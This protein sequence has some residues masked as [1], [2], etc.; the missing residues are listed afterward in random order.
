MAPDVDLSRLAEGYQHRPP[1]DASLARARSA[2]S[3]LQPGSMILDV[4]GG[5]GHHAAVWSA[6]GHTP[7]VLDPGTEMTKPA[8]DRNVT[9]VRGLSQAL[10]FGDKRIDLVWFHLSIH[11]GD[12]RAAADEAL[13]VVRRSGRIEIWTLASDHHENSLLAQWFPAVADIDRAR[14]PAGADVETHLATAGSSV[15]RSRVIEQRT[16]TAGEWVDAVEAGFVSTLQ[17]V[18]EAELKSG[19]VAFQEAHPDPSVDIAY[20][21]RLDRVVAQR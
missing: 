5:P 7:I 3:E 1:S 17:L 8:R 21:L 18:D 19:L 9:V 14:F 10:P 13:R 20:E 15:Q 2:G 16:R 11:Y 4:G 6:Q 12:W